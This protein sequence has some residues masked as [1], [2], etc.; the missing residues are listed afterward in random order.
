WF[1]EQP[2]LTARINTVKVSIEDCLK[3]L[4]D[5]DWIVEQDTYIPEV[6]YIDGHQGHLEKAKPV[7]EGHI[8]FMDKGNF[9]S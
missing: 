1:N 6:V 8:T 7:L 5:L 9:F 3:E 2:R 4:E